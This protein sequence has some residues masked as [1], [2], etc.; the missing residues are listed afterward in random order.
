[1]SV[2]ERFN[3]KREVYDKIL[4]DLNKIEDIDIFLRP[5]FNSNPEKIYNINKAL[6]YQKVIKAKEIE[7]DEELNF[8]EED[9]LE[10]ENKKKLEKLKKYKRVIEF[11]LEFAFKDGEITLARINEIMKEDEKVLKTLIPTIEIFREV[12]IEFLKSGVI[13]IIEVREES[14]EFIENGEIEFRLIK[15]ILE[16]IDE[17]EIFKNIKSIETLKMNSTEE[18]KLENVLSEGG[19]YKNCVCSNVVFKVIKK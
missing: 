3:F 19:I 11:I 17:N 16:I 12:I 6:E 18:V 5:L 9:F 1:M 4:D 13:D 14:K 8:D 7:N 2:I 15:N 10:E